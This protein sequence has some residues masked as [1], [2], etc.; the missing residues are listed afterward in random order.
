MNKFK[1]ILILSAAVLIA[2]SNSACTKEN[3]APQ[4]KPGLMAS[5]S[6]NVAESSNAKVYAVESIG[7]V[8]SG[9]ATDF[10]FKIDGKEQS[11]S[12]LTKGKTVFLNFWGTWCGP[13]RREIPDII[14]ISKDL[15]N[16]NFIVIGMA[17]EREPELIDRIK[18]VKD[19]ANT[20]GIPYMIFIA[21][22]EIID[23]YGGISAVPT[24]FII[25]GKGAIAETI[26][27]SRGKDDFMKSI[28]RVLK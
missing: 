11:F 25:D 27:G 10:K 3:P 12:E 16:K 28:N 1:Q 15:S 18:K 4:G 19:F 17:L 9:K 20:K 14:E 2:F 7:A 13:C 21:N 5:A 22:T 26:V 23:A 6:G 24:T 8:K